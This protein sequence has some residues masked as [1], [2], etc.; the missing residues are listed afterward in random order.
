MFYFLSKTLD[1]FLLPLSWVFLVLLY[2]FFTKR[3]RRARR[4]V[5]VLC[6]GLYLVANPW[7]TNRLMLAWEA[8]PVAWRKLPTKSVVVVLSGVTNPLKQ[9]ADRVYLNKGADRIMHTVELFRRGYAD[10]ILVSGNYTL[11]SG[12]VYSEAAQIK[13]L[14][15]VCGV[16][17]SIIFL[18]EAS[19]NTR[20]NAVY[21]QRWLETH[22]GKPSTDSVI[23]VTSAFHI[24]R[25]VGCFR[26]ENVPVRP[27]PTDFYSRNTDFNLKML[28]PTQKAMAVSSILCREIAGYLVY[29]FMGYL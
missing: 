16:P 27:F 15:Q 9:P 17:D 22:I 28:L 21:S 26:K 19:K 25:A 6:L 1:F 14:L 5:A 20:E 29:K 11:L 8:P 23:L 12:K 24:R 7:L 13:H 10:K 2:A 18:E 3:R 4:A